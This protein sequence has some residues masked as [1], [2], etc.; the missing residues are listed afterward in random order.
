MSNTIKFIDT[1]I[2]NIAPTNK[3]QIFWCDGCPGFGLRIT[4]S[5]TKTFLFKYMNT[6]SSGKRKSRWITIGKYPEWSIRKARR[7]YDLL[8]EH[9]YA[10][11]RDLVE[12]RNIEKSTN[13][14]NP[15]VSDFIETYLE[16]C[17]LKEKA[18]VNEEER[19]FN[20]DVKPIIGDFLLKD[21]TPS[22][23]DKIQSRIL[24]R[25]TKTPNASKS[26][27]VAVK[28]SLAYTRQLFNFAKNKGLVE[29]NPVSK[30][31]SLGTSGSRSR[32]LSLVEIW[33]FWNKLEAAGIPPV[34]ASA[35]KFILVTMQRSIEVRNM[36]YSS[37]KESENVWQM[38]M[39]E[40][41]N[42]TMHRVPLNQHALDII[43]D[44]S[45]FTGA[46]TYVFGATRSLSPPT[47]R[48]RDLNPMGK[49]ALPQAIRKKRKVL[50]IDDFCPH[51][52]RRTGAT[53]ITAVGLPKLYAR[54][55]LNHSDGDRDVTGEVYIQYSY[56]FEK[57]RA[58]KVWEF[59]LDQIIHCKSPEEIPSLEKLRQ[60]VRNSSLL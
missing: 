12:E 10:Y 3:R 57:Q 54:L 13:S 30:V 47:A 39:H 23:I 41:K 32:V 22:E 8:Y 15:T 27:K 43:E 5:G 50:D 45:N 56:D 59:I 26:G 11:G 21:V 60:R 58:A 36:R 24:K 48:K 31:A 55:M 42:K 29:T 28:N 51:D 40:T 18:S 37:I 16:Y 33:K 35:L 53:W 52:L 2:R 25:A 34:T 17:R 19:V 49:T 14:T 20:L 9:V 46:S 44:V 4:P 1:V 7:E 6:L 38:E